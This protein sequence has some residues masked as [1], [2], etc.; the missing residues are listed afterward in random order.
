MARAG[1]SGPPRVFTIATGTPFLPTLVSA[2]TSGALTGDGTPPDSATLAATRIFV[3]TRRAAAALTE[4]LMAAAHGRP[5]LLPRILPLGDGE[6][7][8]EDGFAA[9]FGPPPAELLPEIG[10]FPRRMA[11]FSM[12]ETWRRA[13]A[14]LRT[15]HGESE[16]F[17]V[18]GTP[19][20]AFTLAGDLARLI[21]ET[22]IEDVPLA[23]LTEA[24]PDAYDPEQHDRYWTLTQRFLAIAAT[25]WPQHLAEAGCI[26]SADALKHRFRSV[27]R[28]LAETRPKTPVIIAGST[29]S[30]TA[31]ADLM[32]AVARLPA[33]AVVLPGLDLVTEEAIWAR[34]GE[35]ATDLPTRYAH[36][37]AQLKRTLAHIGIVREDVQRLPAASAP[38]LREALAAA[39]FRPAFAT[40]DWHR[41]KLGPG[42]LDGLVLIEADDEREEALAIALALRETLQ[43]EAASA[44]LVTPDRALARMVRAELQRWNIVAQDSAG[45]PLG[46]AP[47]GALARLTL[48]AAMPGAG[49]LEALALLRHPEVTLGGAD[50]RDALDALEIAAMRCDPGL[51]ALPLVAR[52]RSAAVTAATHRDP[53]PR[54]RLTDAA[55]DAAVVLAE[56][57][58]AALTPLQLVLSGRPTLR[59]AA[60]AHQT[61]IASLAP[62]D[63]QPPRPDRTALL[64]LF[65]TLTDS[66]DEGPTVS[67][68]DYASIIGQ[69]LGEVTVPPYGPAHPRLHIRGLL[70]ARL[71]EADRVVL[72]GLDEGI[73]P[74]DARSDPFLNRAMRVS[75][76]L[77]PPERRIGQT[78]HD[79]MMLLGGANVVLSRARKR[80]GAPTVASRFLRRLTAFIGEKPAE[81]LRAS[82]QIYLDWARALDHPA[83]IAA[84]ERPAPRIPADLMPKQLS[85]TEIE[86]L[87]RDPYALFARRVLGLAPLNPLDPAP[88][89]AARGTIIHAALAR[90]VEQTGAAIPPDADALLRRLGTEAFAAIAATDPETTAFW[91]Q[92]FEAFVPW[93]IAWDGARRAEIRRLH[94]EAGGRL[95]LPLGQGHQIRLNTRADR[96]E[97]RGDG[98]IAIT[99]YKTGTPPSQ[100]VVLA[101][102]SPQL[103][104]T[105]ALLKRGAFADVPAPPEDAGLTLSYLHV[106]KAGG[107]GDERIITSKGEP[108]TDVIERQFSA[109]QAHLTEYLK[110]QRGFT[111]RRIPQVTRY[112]SP[113]DPLA[114]HLEWSQGGEDEEEPA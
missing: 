49:S 110:G 75:L 17:H 97:E 26:D 24:L 16:P 12:I 52:A 18:A 9:G 15:D 67:P 31:T 109:L 41:T 91:Q 56:T 23:R 108:I 106:A 38:S 58:E 65:A 7:L 70:E 61:A 33:G 57:L 113:Y 13:M 14:S 34:I 82:G 78:A 64:S 107:T 59:Q 80:G 43:D 54:R 94:P 90:Y 28:W 40:A 46:Q 81:H 84:T 47:F 21:D 35:D 62:T 101:G 85:L 72:A 30:V 32:A 95:D 104:L 76:G 22:I 89:L 77:Q 3:P 87:Y 50:Y 45:E 79:F 55:L 105:A 68:S 112:D 63:D 10:D 25:A 93:F 96:I 60:I 2:L 6:A 36:P 99:D 20:D 27:A 73:W 1:G 53:A 4:A 83:R 111:S 102:L 39:L 19:A 51:V 29:G 92:R 44:A 5:I 88:D 100:K 69:M 8:A 103:T 98:T 48:D 11:L 42:S 114:R 74:P 66:A 37:Q 86:T 71:L